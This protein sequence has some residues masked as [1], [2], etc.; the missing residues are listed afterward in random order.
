MSGFLAPAGWNLISNPGIF[1]LSS[2]FGGASGA[3]SAL[4]GA[5]SS[6]WPMA[7]AG[8]G[9]G[10][11]QGIFGGM[12]ADKSASAARYTAKQARKTA[13]EQLKEQRR[14]FGASLG[15]DTAASDRDLARQFAGLRFGSEFMANSPAFARN[16][17]REQMANLAS[18]G[19]S[20]QQ[21][22]LAGR[23]MA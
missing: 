14:Q 3:T 6:M 12:A 5:G 13:K 15:Y 22:A 8:L 2:S 4:S 7:I 18:L 9:S 23:F 21:M 11:I 19:Q 20:P 17:R 10:L 1:N 16:F